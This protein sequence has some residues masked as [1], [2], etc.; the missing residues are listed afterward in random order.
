MSGDERILLVDA[1]VFITLAKIGQADLLDSLHGQPEMPLVVTEEV[2]DEPASSALSDALDT[3]LE[4]MHV[5]AASR[6]VETFN[7][8][9]SSAAAH[10]DAADPLADW[11]GDVALLACALVRREQDRDVIVVTDDKP[12]RKTCKTLSIPLSGS[13]GVLVRAVERGDVSPDGARENLYAMDE[14]GTRLSAS[15]VKRAEQMIDDAAD[16]DD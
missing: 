13:I 8:A 10:L 7:T 9:A 16:Y 14:V 4:T 5:Q 1:S 15:L 11:H 6:T 12:L 3:W 2:T